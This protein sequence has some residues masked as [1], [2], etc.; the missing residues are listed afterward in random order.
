M[1]TFFDPISN[2][3]MKSTP[4]QAIN[5]ENVSGLLGGVLNNHGHFA[6]FATVAAAEAA[7]ALTTTDVCYVDETATF[8]RYCATCENVRDGTLILDTGDGGATRWESVGKKSH[9]MGDTGWINTDNM[10]L[11]ALNTTTVRITLTGIGEYAIKGVGYTLAIGTHDVVLDGA[12]G[13]KFIGVDETGTLYHQDTLWDFDTQCPVSITYWTGTAIAAAPQTEYHGIR[14]TVWHAYTHQYIGLQ[15]KSGLTFTGSVQ[16]D[17]TNAP[18]DSTV[19]YLWSTDGVVQDEDVASTPGVGQWLQTLGTGLTAG[20]AGIFNYFYFNGTFVTTLPAMADRT[21]FIHGGGVTFPYWNNA[22][23]L[24][25]ASDNSYVVYHYFATPM[26]GGWAIFARP[27]NA[28]YTTLATAQ[29]ARPSQLTWSNYAELKHIYTAVFRTRT[30]FTNATH[31]C[32]LVSLQ[33]F[34]NVSGGPVTATAATDHNALSNRGATNSH[35]IGAVYGT[36]SGAIP[37]HSTSS[38]GLVESASLTWDNV[39]EVLS[40]PNI[41]GALT[42][43]DTTNNKKV[44]E[45]P[46]DVTANRVAFGDLE[47]QNNGTKLEIDDATGLIKFS[48]V[49]ALS[50]LYVDTSANALTYK[51]GSILAGYDSVNGLAYFGEGTLNI[52]TATGNVGIG[53]T[54][55]DVALDVNGFTQLGS[56]APKIKVK[57]LTG[58]TGAAEGNAVNVAHGLTGGKIL[59]VTAVVFSAANVG[60]LLETTSDAGYQYHVKFDATNVVVTNHATNSENILSK[61]F[62]LTLIYEE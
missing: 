17:N 14:D 20:T 42:I 48:N 10:T 30:Q 29:L 25:E 52:L 7:T 45:F 60:W 11:T 36:I 21:P 57:K 46:I 22:G 2:K 12:A 51:D 13:P 34:R 59:A 9:K 61:S 44:A 38:L 56:D 49:N 62:T 58:T 43:R 5:H 18:A 37:F 3:I 6:S 54:T 31:R 1:S 4:S 35:P 33:D 39:N 24:E 16:A 28:Q 8:Y 41:R 40:L 55:P 50:G 53:T 26:V 27:H 47:A 15:Y 19:Q 32:K 23:T